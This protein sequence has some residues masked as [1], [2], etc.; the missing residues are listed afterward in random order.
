MGSHIF[1]ESDLARL[2]LTLLILALG[3][4]QRPEKPEGTAA[5]AGPISP[6]WVTVYNPKLAW[7]GYTLTLHDV[8]I[9]VLLDMN[10]RPVHGWPRAR[11]KTRVRLLADGSILGIGLGQSV[12]E[13]DWEGRQTWEFRTPRALPH[14]DVLRLAN[15]NTLVLILPDG[16]RAD[17]LLEVDRAG[18]VVWTWRA[19]E[20]LG[21]LIPARPAHPND[22]THINS[23]QELPEN[24]W[25]A[26][27]DR[28]FR[29]GNLLLSA[30]NLNAVFVVDRESGEVV[31]WH[32]D[33]L[34][35]QHE[36]LMNGPGLPAPGRIQLFNNRS[37]SFAS[38]RQSELLEIDPRDGSVAWRYRSPGFFSPTGGVQQALPNGNVLV[39]S[40]RG[41]RV[42]EITRE[43]EIAWEWVPPYYEPVRAVRVAP[44]ACPQLARLAAPIPRAVVPSPRYRH[45]DREVYR[46]ARRGSRT[47]AMVSGEA[48]VV[49][50]QEDDCRGLMLP[51]AATV[52]VGYGVDRERLRAAGR[53][54]RPPLF[55]MRLRPA[56]AGADVE[57][58]R[59]TV[60]LDG[61]SWRQRKIPLGA[62]GFQT[63]RLCVE[64]D[65]GTPGPARQRERFAYWEQPLISTPRD[66]ARLSG[67]DGDGDSPGP[68]PGDL[69]PEELEVRR[70]HLKALG[71]VG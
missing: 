5:G 29:P 1:T 34:D 64:I 30:R 67:E 11:V 59:D 33:G 18:K 25:H 58:L 41:G 44:D 61:P 50:K 38:D 24:P 56:G 15:G 19:I 26:A 49:L 48:R 12:V 23:L 7:N 22:L 60:G 4:G 36:A 35:R 51:A 14:H 47:K 66:A 52:Q 9:P 28:R 68:V 13:Y 2:A 27:G 62:Y 63:V 3:C 32:R 71:Y 40:T 39:T 6:E 8:R 54:D 10:G 46:F 70:K 31:W 21:G 53:A 16:E 37:R 43:G 42:F 20:H 69:S 45:V 57:L 17:T 55:T 65:G